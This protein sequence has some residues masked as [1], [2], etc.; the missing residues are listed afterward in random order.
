MRKKTLNSIF[1]VA[2]ISIFTFSG[3]IITTEAARPQIPFYIVCEIDM[4]SIVIDDKS[5]GDRLFYTIAYTCNITDSDLGAYTDGHE[6]IGGNLTLDSIVTGNRKSGDARSTS[7]LRIIS[8][9]GTLLE[10]GRMIATYE[11]YFGDPNNIVTKIT[12][13]GNGYVMFRGT[14]EGV[15]ASTTMILEGHHFG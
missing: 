12:F 7:V 6:V 3:V 5:M 13:F 14:M 15:G 11:N 4:D 2:L 8:A 1:I 9:D 10:K